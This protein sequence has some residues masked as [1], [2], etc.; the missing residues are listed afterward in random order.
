MCENYDYIGSRRDGAF[1]EYVAVPIWNLIELPDNVTFAEAAL[2]EP[3]AVALHAIKKA[4]INSE[5]KTVAIIGTGMIG[6]VAA[7]WAKYFGAQC[8]SVIGR[9]E[10]KRS[11]VESLGD[12]NYL[13]DPMN[14]LFDVVIEAVGTNA[15]IERA[16][17][18]VQPGG[19][20]ILTGNPE[21]DIFLAKKVYWRI[22]RKQLRIIGTWNSFY[23]KDSESDWSETCE[24]MNLGVIKVAQTITHMY[25][26][27]DLQK[28][29]ELMKN[30]KE[31]YCK[32]MILW[33]QDC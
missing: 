26:Q 15:S 1:A 33:N 31:P 24:A 11:L 21:N 23:E 25:E 9:G 27:I 30:H 19:C 8:V 28:G 18:L 13:T 14:Q 32:V 29:L 3:V 10:S 12:I 17:N 16:V 4:N 2:L 6:C 7:Q 5:T 22:L 20:L